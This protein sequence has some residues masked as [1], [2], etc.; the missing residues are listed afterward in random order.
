VGG[1]GGWA[2]GWAWRLGVAA[3]GWAAGVA[4][5]CGGRWWRLV[6]GAALRVASLGMC[7]ASSTLSG[8]PGQQRPCRAAP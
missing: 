2:W 4:G 5:R 1:L 7:E 8:T 3:G 6:P